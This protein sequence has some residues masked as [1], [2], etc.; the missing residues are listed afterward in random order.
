MAKKSPIVKHQKLGR[1][2]AHGYWLRGKVR[3]SILLD[4]R[5][6]GRHKLTIT[7]HELLHAHDENLSEKQV[8]D[9]S[10]FL[11][12]ELWRLGYRWTDNRAR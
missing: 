1:E 12:R 3:D 2:K 7:M 6:K 8:T 11:S 10:R 4:T 9:T 5:L